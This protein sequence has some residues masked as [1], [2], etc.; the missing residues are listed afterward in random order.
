MRVL[1]ALVMLV[2]LIALAVYWSTNRSRA[3]RLA[4]ELDLAAVELIDCV[5]EARGSHA[6]LADTIAF[7]LPEERPL[8]SC[9]ERS[10]RAHALV[11][12]LSTVKPVMDRDAL[13]EARR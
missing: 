3:K 8:A 9:Q 1:I 2:P 11:S 7:A 6:T 10:L 13:D 12:E 5:W 4:R